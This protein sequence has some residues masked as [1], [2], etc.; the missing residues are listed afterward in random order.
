L[1]PARVIPC[2]LLSGSGLVKT[3][4]FKDR[5]YIG[6]PRNA[7]RIFNEREVDELVVLDI[8]ASVE[9][10]PPQFEL[11]RE[12]VSEAFMPVGYGGGIATIDAARRMLQLGVEK[13]VVNTAAVERPEFVTEL[14]RE[15]GSQSVVVS[16]DV[17]RSIFGRHEVY[18][19]GGRTRAKVSPVE[20]ARRMEACGAGELL[21]NSIERDGTRTGY[22]IELL[23]SVTAAVRVPVVA[24]GG[25]RGLE[26]FRAAVLEGGASAVAAGSAFVLHGRHRAVLIS[27]PEPAELQRTFAGK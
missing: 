1:T 27:Y 7:V 8:D 12:I 26:D 25:A 3:V 18:A 2:L 10:K 13:L 19:R 11:V 6:D 15:F 14:A 16:V 24:C 5:K 9:R 22:D 21:L 17:N 23:R 4:K 20:F